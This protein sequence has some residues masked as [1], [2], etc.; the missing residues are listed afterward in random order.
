[1]PN[2]YQQFWFQHPPR[3]RR[4]ASQVHTKLIV[5]HCEASE[6]ILVFFAVLEGHR[7]HVPTCAAAEEDNYLAN[8]LAQTKVLGDG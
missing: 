3:V 4:H 1:M 7:N 6:R 5:G 8:G 2:H